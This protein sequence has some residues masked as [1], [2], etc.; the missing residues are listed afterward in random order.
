[1]PCEKTEAAGTFSLFVSH[2]I[3]PSMHSAARDGRPPVHL[4]KAQG[5]IWRAIVPDRREHA[6]LKESDMADFQSLSV[7][8]FIFHAHGR[9]GP[10][11]SFTMWQAGDG[12][13]TG[14]IPKVLAIS[15][16][17]RA[18][19]TENQLQTAYLEPMLRYC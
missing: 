6:K 15:A 12:P 5:E 13:S 10:A 11:H 3:H 16:T 9:R 14:R 19:Y 1:M 18:K 7:A 17:F 8:S 2:S 4:H